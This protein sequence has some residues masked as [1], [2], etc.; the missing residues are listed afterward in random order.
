MCK[1]EDKKDSVTF[2]G[3]AVSNLHLEKMAEVVKDKFGI[4][5]IKVESG[6]S[7]HVTRE[8]GDVKVTLSVHDY[9]RAATFD[10]LDCLN[11]VEESSR[12]FFR[13]K[14]VSSKECRSQNYSKAG[15]VDILKAIA[16]FAPKE[17]PSHKVA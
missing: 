9:P 10:Y 15:M 1:I 14:V 13:L 17:E 2:D 7:F 16:K 4:E 12:Q 3:F 11:G 5:N 8:I 6:T